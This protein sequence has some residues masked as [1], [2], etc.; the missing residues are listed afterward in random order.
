[1]DILK[2][3]Y[4]TRKNHGDSIALRSAKGELS[5]A[6][7][8]R[9]SDVLA[10]CLIRDLGDDRKP[11]AVYGHK[12]PDMIVAFLACMKSGRAYCP[13]D[14]S[15][16]VQR[17]SDILEKIGND[18]LIITE[19]LPEG[20][21]G[22]MTVIDVRELTDASSESAGAT[23][24]AQN[25]SERGGT[26]NRDIE[27][28]APGE[29]YRIKDDD[30]CYIIF[31][32]GSTGKPK[33]VQV[34]YANLNNFVEWSV[35]LGGDREAKR[36]STFLNQAPFSFDLSVM[37]LY[38]CLSTGGRLWMLDKALQTD[39]EALLSDLEKADINYWV[40]TP[41]FV[42][43][44]LVDP[45]FNGELLKDMKAFL[46]CG[47]KLTKKTA[48]ALLEAF[49]NSKVVNTYGPTESTVAV[50]GVEITKEIM[51]EEGSL[52]VGTP[53]AG[54]EILIKDEN[55]SVLPDGEIGE[56]NI[57][58][59]TVAIG[60][61]EE[62]PERTKAFFEQD[63]GGT[64]LKGY[65]TGDKGYKKGDMLYCCG[66]M[67]LQIKLHGY[68]IELG[69]IERNLLMLPG[70]T[71]AAVLPRTVDE[72]IKSLTAFVTAPTLEDTFANKKDIKEKLKE[73]LP[74]YMIPKKIVFLETMPVNANGKTD[75]KALEKLV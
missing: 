9:R 64:R 38:T 4:E 56:I 16:S 74:S 71:A 68:R 42:D 19:D 52:P 11:I 7:L 72:T 27:T 75:R 50:T 24:G 13:I 47:E 5:Y 43:M 6:E 41:S 2:S 3:I 57:L 70:I 63:F 17:A 29:K 54:T 33:G 31:T 37:D 20:T 32:S 15:M 40:S 46:F 49:P 35:D 61:Y 34:S 30:P 23:G 53:K 36:G 14:I 59:D 25:E 51:E 8:W 39:A 10:E 18:S 22:G 48:R 55:G 65:R 21:A 66:R 73:F 44:L 28:G 45:K 58:G 12:S 69:D 26:P 1:M 60:Y 62:S 67:D